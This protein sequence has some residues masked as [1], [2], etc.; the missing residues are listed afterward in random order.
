MKFLQKENNSSLSLI[1][2]DSECQFVGR[3]KRQRTDGM[4]I[5]GRRWQEHQNENKIVTDKTDEDTKG[6][7]QGLEEEICVVTWNVNTSSAQY[8]FL[9]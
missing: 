3:R 2:E 7:Q 5:D 8:D 9:L 1:A 4:K 6:R